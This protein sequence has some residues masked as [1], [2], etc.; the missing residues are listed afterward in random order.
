[1]HTPHDPT[2]PGTTLA[3]KRRRLRLLAISGTAITF[4]VAVGVTYVLIASK[5]SAPSVPNLLQIGSKSAGRLGEVSQ[6][7][8]MQ[9]H[10]PNWSEHR[11]ITI[12]KYLRGAASVA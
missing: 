2:N 8:K 3:D 6:H 4:A 12:G 7:V 1:M 11:L 9:A 5:S 10:G